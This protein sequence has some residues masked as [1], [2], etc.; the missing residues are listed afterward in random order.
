MTRRR[1][2][3]KFLSVAG[4]VIALIA[5]LLIATPASAVVDGTDSSVPWVVRV[6]GLPSREGNGKVCSGS[7]ISDSWMLTAKHCVGP[8]LRYTVTRALTKNRWETLGT[9]S[10]VVTY[11]DEDLALMKLASPVSTSVLNQY[12]RLSTVA[13]QGPA[14]AYGYGK[15]A[16]DF[17]FPTEVQQAADVSIESIG[18]LPLS[19]I[20]EDRVAWYKG[21]SWRE[22]PWS[23]KVITTAV[24]GQVYRG[25]SGGPLVQFGGI[26]AVSSRWT[27]DN[28]ESVVISPDVYGWVAK[29]TSLGDALS[30]STPVDA[31]RVVLQANVTGSGVEVDTS[32]S[33]VQERLPRPFTLL[34]DSS[35]AF[36]IRTPSWECLARGRKL[37]VVLDQVIPESTLVNAP[38]DPMSPEQ[39][40]FFLEEGQA[41]DSSLLGSVHAVAGGLG[42]AGDTSTPL[43]LVDDTNTLTMKFLDLE[44]SGSSLTSALRAS[45]ATWR[46]KPSPPSS[47]SEVSGIYYSTLTTRIELPAIPSGLQVDKLQLGVQGGNQ[48]AYFLGS[49]GRVYKSVLHGDDSGF[50][51][52]V[53]LPGEKI[54]DLVVSRVSGGAAYHDG[55]N[56]YVSYG[57]GKDDFAKLPNNAK[58]VRMDFT[59]TNSN[60]GQAIY[61]VGSD[62]RAYRF[63]EGGSLYPLPGEGVTNLSASEDT[64]GAVLYTTSAGLRYFEPGRLETSL[65]ALPAGLQVTSLTLSRQT[66]EFAYVT[67][68]DGQVYKAIL[69]KGR[70]SFTP[71]EVQPS[72]LSVDDV[73][74]STRGGAGAVYND[75]AFAYV[76]FGGQLPE[77]PNRES[78]AKTMLTT[79]DR[80]E[81]YVYAISLDDNL[82]R[83]KVGT[84]EWVK[85]LGEVDT[86]TVSTNGVGVLFAVARSK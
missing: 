25:D 21:G 14:I 60:T 71:W 57:R 37:S 3:R 72:F 4:A 68:D 77:L 54:V 61:V 45:T 2:R 18:R 65:P 43:H 23:R 29:T 82:Y 31:R 26:T 17:A 55:T 76:T 47:S 81:P 30:V 8:D 13:A 73:S 19:V 38:C 86:A 83:L 15:T 46:N 33:A 27:P 79:D 74:V 44:G 78:V 51:E 70:R 66:H 32:Q 11:P 58:I 22:Y 63:D 7:M 5:S 35:N 56:L 34:F 9:V 12:G 41:A 36:Q 42:V 28:V 64:D 39:K 69:K 59:G 52:W 62:S 40:F 75:G 20:Y 24:R 80:A 1:H 49:D 67:L 16:F 50:S 48:F 53:K 85:L 6:T 10:Q 84:R